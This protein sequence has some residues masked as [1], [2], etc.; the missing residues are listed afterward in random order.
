M[1]KNVIFDYSDTLFRFQAKEYLTRILGGDQERAH[2]LHAQIFECPLWLQFDYGLISRANHKQEA[3][4]TLAPEDRP[5]A[6]LYLD[7]W[8]EHYQVIN[9]M[10]EIIH[11]LKARGIKLFVLSNYPEVFELVHARYELLHL[12][13]GRLISYEAGTGKDDPEFFRLLMNKYDLKP[14]E[15]MYFDDYPRFIKVARALGIDG[16]TFVSADETRRLLG[17]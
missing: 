6:D 3:L 9:G 13:D 10:P 12:F 4:K 11:D 5:A 8:H 17:L 16:H 7:H 14:E 1:Y 2:R 15:C